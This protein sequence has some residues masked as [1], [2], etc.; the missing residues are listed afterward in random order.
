MVRPRLLARLDEG[1]RGPLTLISAAAGTGKTTLLDQ[2]QATTSMP[3]ARL[4]L[5]RGDGEPGQGLVHVAAALQ[6]IQPGAGE[7]LH[8]RDAAH[9]PD[10]LIDLVNGLA[11]A[12]HD[13]ALLLDNYEVLDG[14]TLGAAL[15]QVIDFVPPQVHLLITARPEPEL[16]LPRLRVRGQLLQLGSADLDFTLEEAGAYLRAAFR[17]LPAELVATLHARTEGWVTGLAHAALAL[18]TARDPAEAAER[19]SGRNLHLAAYLAREV[20]DPQAQAVQA[21]LLQTCHLDTLSAAACD[22]ATGRHDSQ[23][24][25]QALER[26]NLFVVPLD[27]GRRLYRYHRLFAEYLQ[28]RAQ[29]ERV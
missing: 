18:R 25:L 26:A 5:A 13:V 28:R 19:F 11:Q 14:S 23:A 6:S 27:A 22:A 15:A 24:M 16:P 2:W 12:P 3:L 9:L 21:F 29:V 8:D 1:M 7:C 4:A 17:A 20:F 10:A